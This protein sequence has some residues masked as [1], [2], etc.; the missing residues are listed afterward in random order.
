MTILFL[1]LKEL[2]SDASLRG[3][4]RPNECVLGLALDPVAP[5]TGK[6]SEIARVLEQ[7]TKTAP[8]KARLDWAKRFALTAIA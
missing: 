4:H 7:R 1:Y 3:D 6:D 2:S 8:L 5:R